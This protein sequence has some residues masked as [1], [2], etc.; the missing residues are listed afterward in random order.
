MVRESRLL[1]QPLTGEQNG[2]KIDDINDWR[3][4][5][6]REN[7]AMRYDFLVETYET[8]RVKVLSVWSE[9]R[10]EDLPVRPREGDPRGRSVREQMIHQCVSED[11]WCRT[12]LGIDVGAPP[13]P[14]PETRLEF[15]KRYAEDSGKRLAVLQGKDEDWWEGET[16]FF[17][18]KRSRA[19]V[20]TR[21]FTHTSHHRGQHMAML[22]MLGRDLHS[23]YGPTA[24]TGGLMQNHAPTVYAYSSIG[25]LVQG[26][27]GGGAKSLLPGARGKPVTERPDS[28]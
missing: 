1:R 25:A 28:K 27:I 9:F 24:D 7:P 22:R 3:T 26:E 2:Y 15:I 6:P 21:R 16:N 5:F 8:E 18:V 23:N 20:M 4:G 14:V 10:D 19:W 12:M 17:D 13:L 11:L